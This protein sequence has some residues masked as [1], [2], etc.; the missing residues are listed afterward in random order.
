MKVYLSTDTPAIASLRRR[1]D[2]VRV[3]DR[4]N[5]SGDPEDAVEIEAKRSQYVQVREADVVATHAPDDE[6]K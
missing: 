2:N 1:S 3:G 5:V 4:H 6:T